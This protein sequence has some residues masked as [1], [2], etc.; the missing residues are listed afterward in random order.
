VKQ[1]AHTIAVSTVVAANIASAEVNTEVVTLDQ[2]IERALLND[3]RISEQKK[4][5]D[6]A[7][8][9]LQ[10][11]QGSDDLIFGLD[12]FIGLTSKVEGGFFENN[13]SSNDP[14][15]DRYEWNGLTTWTNLQLTIIK[16]LYTFGKIENY[17]DAAKSN[18][19][20]K[21]EDVRKQRADTIMDAN[22][23]YYGY[24]A[25]RDTRYLFKDV[26]V[27][28]N[29]AIKLVKRRLADSESED[30]IRQ[31]D[32]YALQAGKALISKY[33][34]QA[35][36]IEKIAM[37]GLK[38]LTGGSLDDMLEVSDKRVTPVPLPDVALDLLTQT[39]LAKRPEMIQ[40]EAGLQARRSL[41]AARQAEKMPNVYAGI[42]AL[43][44]YAPNRTRLDN[45][46]IYDPFNDY[47]A[48]PLLGIKWNWESGVHAA[49]V[50][51]AE[52]ELAALVE[53]ST[54]AQRGIPFE[55]A[56]QY[57][58]VQGGYEAVQNLA[59]G[60]RAARRWMVSSYADFEA[61][62]GDAEDSLTAF[63]GYVLVHS[64]YLS[65]VNDYN[66]NVA[67]LRYV[68]GEYQ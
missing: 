41:I 50:A 6:V 43:A 11:A 53:K 31:S 63:Q 39:A 58:Q 4:L 62:I 13:N 28:L 35:A 24:L 40:L 52:A 44:S 27:R 57:Y 30:D 15:S 17:S 1:W 66:M 26:I 19:R 54:F 18:I 2:V 7:R 23:A 47:G 16:P 32:L 38:V 59:Q 51:R 68:V 67:R 60:S 55:V 45:P 65:A 37:A 29:G 25:A 61:G 5:V 49:R 36:A 33:L 46:F 9:L 21:E 64:D 8:T 14:R 20:V 48:T 34:A 42:A 56:E 3:P 12:A 10:E 22:R